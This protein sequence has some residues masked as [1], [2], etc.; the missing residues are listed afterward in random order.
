MLPAVCRAGSVV[1]GRRAGDSRGVSDAPALAVDQ[2]LAFASLRWILVA[3]FAVCAAFG[4][5][6]VAVAQAQDAVATSRAV[7]TLAALWDGFAHAVV[8]PWLTVGLLGF[9]CFCLFYEMLTPKTWR[10]AGNTGALCV[11][12]VFAANI[13][14]KEAGWVGVLLLLLGLTLI[15][16]EVHLYPGFGAALAGF[17]IMFAGMF[18]ALGGVQHPEFALPLTLV[19]LVVSG[20]AFLAYL[21]QSP[22]WKRM[23]QKIHEHQ[24]LV[25]AN[26]ESNVLTNDEID[27]FGSSFLI[28]QKGRVLTALRPTGTAEFAGKTRRV[29]TEGDFLEPGARVVVIRIEGD[30]IVVD[31]VGDATVPVLGKVAGR[32][33]NQK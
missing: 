25:A 4:A 2:G 31:P 27:Y 19:L 1:F 17:I 11:G 13:A 5:S 15:L 8:N 32:V 10:L 3:L 16:L 22:A 20:I 7:P 12:L 23:G 9:G 28:G 14:V 18:Q 21:P 26:F 29:V 24:A 30:R 6:G 33:G